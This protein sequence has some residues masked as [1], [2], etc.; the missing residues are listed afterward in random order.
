MK[1][2]TEKFLNH[3]SKL[4]TAVVGLEVEFYLKEFSF[5]K[6]LEV[7]NHEFHPIQIHGFRSYHPN[8]NPTKDKWSLTPDSSGG[9]NLVELITGPVDYFTAKIFLSKIIKFVQNYGYTTDKCSVHFNISFNDPELNLSDLNTLKMILSVDEENIYNY[10]PDRIDNVYAKS[11]KGIVPF[12][13]YDFYNIP[14]DSV[15]TNL[16]LP[17]DKY[18]GINFININAPK[19]K[20][21]LEFRYIG[22]KDYE[23][24]LGY[25]NY[26]LDYFVVLTYDCIDAVF[27]QTDIDNL[28]EYLDRRIGYYRG[29]S[30]YDSFLMNYPSI[31]LQINQDDTYEIV[32]SYYANIYNRIFTLLDSIDDLK[33]CIL[34][35]YTDKNIFEV[36]SAERVKGTSVLKG[37][38]FV[39]CNIEGIL[40]SCNVVQ[41]EVSDSQLTSCKL[42][43]TEVKESKLY[44]CHVEDGVVID[45]FFMGGYLNT[46]MKGGVFRLGEL[47][48]YGELD[49]AVIR[50]ED[51][52]NF[53]GVDF[54]EIERSS[55]EGKKKYILKK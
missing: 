10:Y 11:V 41:C 31:N 2:Y 24:N 28:E 6:T 55:G 9:Q 47:G 22:G 25:L 30:N 50:V 12:K 34:N 19:E 21:R 14:I 53:F 26:F 16:R 51:S 35:Y 43:D 46:D 37:Y 32:S 48:P 36:I 15:R 1:K 54:G 23:K 52:D 17:D 33:E 44:N 29:L 27:D 39:D 20:Q 40:S 4:K 3:S 13:E 7:L 42:N 5:Y 38:T 45:S 49:S 18:Y 8:F